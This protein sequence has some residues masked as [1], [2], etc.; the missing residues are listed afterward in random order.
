MGKFNSYLKKRENTMRP[1][2]V[3]TKDASKNLAPFYLILIRN[4]INS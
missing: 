4:L 3:G 2:L 1:P